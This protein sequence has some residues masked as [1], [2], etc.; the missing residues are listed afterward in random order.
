MRRIISFPIPDQLPAMTVEPVGQTS[1]AT[2]RLLFV[3]LKQRNR[4]E[5]IFSVCWAFFKV[6][7]SCIIRIDFD[8]HLTRKLTIRKLH[9]VSMTSCH[10][11][12]MNKLRVTVKHIYRGKGVRILIKFVA[13]KN[14]KSKEFRANGMRLRVQ[15]RCFV[16]D[17]HHFEHQTFEFAAVFLIKHFKVLNEVDGCQDVLVP[18]VFSD[19][20]MFMFVNSPMK[21]AASVTCIICITQITFEFVYYTFLVYL[22]WF[23]GFTSV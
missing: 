20:G 11:C 18:V 9:D 15:F 19:H 10:H 23:F 3:S 17:K 13:W 8:E 7:Y 4:T 22:G 21:V 2:I 1:T 14:L 12:R 16:L 6:K 5:R